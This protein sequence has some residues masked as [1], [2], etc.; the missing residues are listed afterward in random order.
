M[1]AS[2]SI[3]TAPSSRG[4]GRRPLKAE[5]AVRIRSGLPIF[6]QNYEQ[7]ELPPERIQASRTLARTL[8]RTRY[9]SDPQ[10]QDYMRGSLS[11]RD[12]VWRSSTGTATYRR[13][14]A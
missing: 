13:S 10:Y 2:W 4:L 12:Y 5:T 8:T 14:A 6:N 11:Q 7:A 3:C 1:T 9:R